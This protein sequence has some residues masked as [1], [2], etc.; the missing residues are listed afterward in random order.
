MTLTDAEL[1]E[2]E[3]RADHC[4][5]YSDERGQLSHDVERLIARV[6]VLESFRHDVSDWLV[7]QFDRDETDLR[8]LVV[9]LD[10]LGVVHQSKDKPTVCPF[11]LGSKTNTKGDVEADCG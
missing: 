11:C 10:R 3:S 4:A 8:A 2:M 6:R 9:L 1:S 7:E 5:I